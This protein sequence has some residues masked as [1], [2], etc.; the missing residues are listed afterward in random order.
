[1]WNPAKRYTANRGKNMPIACRAE[2]RGKV[3]L[4]HMLFLL[5]I[6]L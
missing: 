5:S 1:M 2:W 6:K 4:V 3:A